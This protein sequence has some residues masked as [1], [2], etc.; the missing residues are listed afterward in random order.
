MASLAPAV[1]DLPFVPKPSV[2]TIDVTGDVVRADMWFESSRMVD[3]VEDEAWL[4][5]AQAPRTQSTGA[6]IKKLIAPSIILIVAAIFIAGYFAFDGET[7]V[8]HSSNKASSALAA[9]T[10]RAGGTASAE[11]SQPPVPEPA[12]TKTEPAVTKTEPAVTKTEPA[13][14]KT[15]PAVTKTEP[16][17]TKTEPAVTKTEPA[18]TKTEPAVTKTEPAVAKTEP[19]AVREVKTSQGVVKLVDVRIDSK[20]SGATVMLVDNGKTSFLGTTPVAAS[21]D[22]SRSYDVILTLE[23]RTTQMSHFDPAR[24]HHVEIA[25]NKGTASAKTVEAAPAPSHHTHHSAAPTTP[26]FADA[27][28]AAGNGQLMVSSKPPCEIY[29]DGQPTGLVTPQRSIPL[30]AGA[31]RITFVNAGQNVNKTVAVAIKND[32]T[33]K[34]IQNFMGD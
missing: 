34:L 17:V 7:Q 18:V 21:V 16:A 31:H 30:S 4:G 19:A 8:R 28:K 1:S 22:P 33:T 23:G 10:A 15:E 2:Q 14:T 6:L 32:Q 25:L 20:P 13:V 5:T 29:V 24:S 26:S 3:K 9:T 12:V 11:K 27:S